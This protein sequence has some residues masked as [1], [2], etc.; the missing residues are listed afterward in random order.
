[1][2]NSQLVE[3]MYSLENN[4]NKTSAGYTSTYSFEIL[5]LIVPRFCVF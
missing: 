2:G 3:T 5:I 1:M 4:K